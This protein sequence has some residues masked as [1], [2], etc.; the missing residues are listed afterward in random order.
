MKR[1]VFVILAAALTSALYGC[2]GGGGSTSSGPTTPFTNPAAPTASQN[3]AT[4]VLSNATV[5]K[6]VFANGS[7][8]RVS[9]TVSANTEYVGNKDYITIN[10]TGTPNN[11]VAE[12]M[13]NSVTGLLAVYDYKA[14]MT[15]NQVR[16]TFVKM[17]ITYNGSI[18][19]VRTSPTTVQGYSYHYDV[20]PV[21][22]TDMSYEVTTPITVT[23]GSSVDFSLPVEIRVHSCLFEFADTP[24]AITYPDGSFTKPMFCTSTA[25]PIALP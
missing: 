5:S 6:P 1:L 18:R 8:A 4:V 20:L 17:P 12:T 16:D 22:N 23:S 13:T 9:F 2:G 19:L 15:R 14:N 21:S 24:A 10:N 25:I 11:F 3:G 7:T